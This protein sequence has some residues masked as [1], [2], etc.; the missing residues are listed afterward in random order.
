MAVDWQ[1]V[2]A[3]ACKNAEQA[4]IASRYRTISGSAFDVDWGTGY[5]LV[6]LTNFL[7]HFNQDTCV[8]LLKKVRGRLAPAGKT[9]AV[10]F[11]PNED[12]VSPYMPAIFSL[13]MLATTPSGDAYTAAALNEMARAAGY[14]RASVI[15]LPPTPQ[16]LVAFEI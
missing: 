14:C 16:S 15:A 9:P 13:I 2:L 1:D 12:R 7:H 10:E 4:G 3:V 11:V 8:T 6:L 5:G